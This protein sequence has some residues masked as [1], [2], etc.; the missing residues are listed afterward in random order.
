MP[1]DAIEVSAANL[2]ADFQPAFAGQYLTWNTHC[3]GPEAGSLTQKSHN[4]LPGRGNNPGRNCCG[5]AG[6]CAHFCGRHLPWRSNGG[7]T[8]LHRHFQ[9]EPSRRQHA[10]TLVQVQTAARCLVTEVWLPIIAARFSPMLNPNNHYI[11]LP[12]GGRSRG[13][14]SKFCNQ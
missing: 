11:T 8:L 5:R 6:F 13:I 1:A 3:P 9:L 2:C 7:M 12:A 14:A 4:C 10:Q